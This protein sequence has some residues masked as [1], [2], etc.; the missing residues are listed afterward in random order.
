MFSTTRRA[1]GVLGVTG[2]LVASL[3][4][5]GTERP[6]EV[7][8]LST[9]FALPADPNWGATSGDSVPIP[10]RCSFERFRIPGFPAPVV[11]DD[12]TLETFANRRNL[13]VEEETATPHPLELLDAEPTDT[14]TSTGGFSFQSLPA[15]A[16]DTL[17]KVADREG[18]DPAVLARLNGCDGTASLDQGRTVHSYRGTLTRHVVKKGESI[19]SIARRHQA[20][21]AALIYLNGLTTTRI[22]PG[23]VLYAPAAPIDA[24]SLS[25]VRSVE[26]VRKL[27]EPP[28]HIL[29]A[30]CGRVSSGFGWR[31]HPVTGVRGF[32]MG[33]DLT[34]P[35]GT[36]IK[37]WKDGVVERAGDM[38]L[39]GTSLV[40]RHRNGQISIYG[41]CQ[42]ITVAV[43]DHVTRGQV[44]A[45]VGSTGRATGSHLHFAIKKAG[46]FVN[47]L[48][49]LG[50]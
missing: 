6:P 2:S 35:A 11:A 14:T 28:Y 9:R 43:G 50:T 33:V 26:W 20:H 25:L 45:R 21:M 27:Y 13:D 49:Y 30:R 32:H 5:V 4:L 29:L 37:A 15:L 44:V 41:H 12:A 18:V 7:V 16:G 36:G 31:L 34:A 1:L 47:P 40:I 19:W 3:G 17:V 42:S 8:R 24:D 38:G 39:M 46:L 10:V 23:D 22:L 48:K